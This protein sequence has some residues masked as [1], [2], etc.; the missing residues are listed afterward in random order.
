V[1]PRLT[2]TFTDFMKLIPMKKIFL[3]LMVYMFSTISF[4]AVEIP[5]SL[6]TSQLQ[7]ST[8]LGGTLIDGVG[9]VSLVARKNGKQVVIF[10]QDSN[11][12][13]IGKAETVVGLKET[14]IYIVAPEGLKKITIQ[15]GIKLH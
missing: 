13:V 6:N 15:W 10:A 7:D 14:P 4:S 2:N 12:K 9:E 11:G 8:E 5:I 1:T 3:F